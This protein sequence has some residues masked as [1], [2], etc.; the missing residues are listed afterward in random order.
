ML[1]ITLLAYTNTRQHFTPQLFRTTEVP[2]LQSTGSYFFWVGMRTCSQGSQASIE[3]SYKIKAIG[4]AYLVPQP[5][6]LFQQPYIAN[7]GVIPQASER[8]YAQ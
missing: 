8:A 3:I 1:S 2:A 4:H 7:I 6:R 5:G